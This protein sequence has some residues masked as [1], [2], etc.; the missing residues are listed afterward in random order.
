ME[1]SGDVL[2]AVVADGS[3]RWRRRRAAEE[4]VR[5]GDFFRVENCMKR[6]F[7]TG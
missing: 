2:G 3:R 4:A 5:G 7:C 6:A 1:V